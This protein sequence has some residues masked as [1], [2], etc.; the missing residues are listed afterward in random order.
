M[1]AGH[2]ILSS[3]VARHR[4]DDIL[5]TAAQARLVEAAI[6]GQSPVRAT[7]RHRVGSLLVRSGE[8]L[9][10]VSRRQPCES[11]EVTAGVMRLAR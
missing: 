9:L 4:T 3:E 5:R 11:A 6:H 2:S 10:T 1:L 8:R 7:M